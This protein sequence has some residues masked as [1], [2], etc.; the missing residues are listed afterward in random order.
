[1]AIQDIYLVLCATGRQG[2]AVVDALVDKNAD[3]VGSSRNPESLRKQKGDSIRV[4]RA[5]MNDT[6]S[7]V[8]ALDESKATRVWFTTDWY[9]IKNPTRAKEA[10]L[11]Y[12]VIDAVCRRSRQV[13]H[14]VYNSGA[15]ADS[16]SE[17]LTEFW[18]KVDVEKYMAKK[19]APLQITWSVLR[20]VSFL[21][22]LDDAKNGNPL[23]KGSLKML[24]K[25]EASMKWISCADIGKGAVVLLQNPEIYAGRKIDA[26]TCEYNGTE[27]AEVLSEVSG[28]PCKYSI[29]VPRPVLWL[30]VH[31]LYR[32][33]VWFESGGY[34]DTDVEEF[35]KMVPDCQDA[36]AWFAAKGCWADGEPFSK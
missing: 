6:A 26:G 35:R 5:D 14:V 22:N 33:V 21:E 3:V 11:G 13:R 25:A 34:D 29:S 32:M 7:I 36:K 28:V 10:R 30:F 31:H 27:L 19:L 16:V 17:K 9:S 2:S 20:P 8:A 1:M 23:T 24:T 12:N 4:V 15:E 18:S